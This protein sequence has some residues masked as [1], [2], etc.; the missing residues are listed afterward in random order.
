M[1]EYLGMTIEIGGEFPAGLVSEFL[2]ELTDELSEINGSTTEQELRQEAKG[3]KAIKWYAQSNYGECD[4]LK[5][6]CR[7]HGLGYIHTSEAK[8]EFNAQVCYW[9][10]GMPE[11]SSN[12]ANQDGDVTIPASEVRP[13]VF[14]LL[15]YANDPKNALPLLI[16]EKNGI[17]KKAVEKGLKKNPKEFLKIIE[18]ELNDRLA[19]EPKLPPLTIKE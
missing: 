3:K 2:K 11:E 13:L 9:V 8:Y 14:A 12:E 5:K 16:T 4:S 1:S 18:K 15:A 17:V 19:I 10:P 7:E 6:F